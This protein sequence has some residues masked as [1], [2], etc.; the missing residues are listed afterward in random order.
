MPQVE[1]TIEGVLREAVLDSSGTFTL[2]LE[3]AREKLEKY[4]SADASTWAW[5][6]IQ[7]AVA[8]GC[9][10]VIIKHTPAD[11]WFAAAVN[12]QRVYPVDEVLE[13][14]EHWLLDPVLSP[15]KLLTSSLLQANAIGCSSL[16][17]GQWEKGSAVS[18]QEFL[19][20]EQRCLQVVVPP[21]EWDRALT[22]QWEGKGRKN[23]N[24]K[25][26]ERRLSFCPIPVIVKGSTQS[27]TDG[28]KHT[29]R[30]L[31]GGLPDLD[32]RHREWE[33]HSQD[34]LG[35]GADFYFPGQ[36]SSGMLL[37]PHLLGVPTVVENNLFEYPTNF[38]AA[39]LPL[40]HFRLVGPNDP[41]CRLSVGP[42]TTTYGELQAFFSTRGENDLTPVQFGVSL[43]RVVGLWNRRGLTV[44]MVADLPSLP[45]DIGGFKLVQGPELETWIA[46]AAARL[47]EAAAQVEPPYDK[48]A[49]GFRHKTRPEESAYM[50]AWVLAVLAAA[51]FFIL[52][53]MGAAGGI[54]S[55]V[56]VVGSI[57]VGILLASLTNPFGGGFQA[58]NPQAHREY[59]PF[60]KRL[61][62]F[63]KAA[64]QKS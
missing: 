62:E 61:A 54:L 13:K 4:Q 40:S 15:E 51:F 39:R 34:L 35:P 49:I 59:P 63:A 17:I 43:D 56:V 12:P 28:Y 29:P 37:R 42:L 7:L 11:R 23:F 41:G 5:R 22:L 38:L 21:V 52:L 9:S 30:L 64:Q 60:F 57:F 8:S 46:S 44:E 48:L 6:W 18:F 2:S 45:T 24:K 36:P 20:R 1:D 53:P 58:V 50:L 31:Q 3:Q 26:F 16:W 14:F 55:P 32:C 10:A 19:G 25:E 33:P 47:A 27:P